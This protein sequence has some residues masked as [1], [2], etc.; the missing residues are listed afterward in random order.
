MKKTKNP[1]YKKGKPELAPSYC[2][3]VDILGF[4]KENKNKKK[5][6][7]KNAALQKFCDV[8]MKATEGLRYETKLDKMIP[9]KISPWKI[10]IF[11]DNILIG[12]PLNSKYF[13]DSESSFGQIIMEITYFQLE[14]ALN[15][16]FSRGGWSINWLYMDENIIY[17]DGLIEAYEL[18]KKAIYPCVILSDELLAIVQGVHMK[19]YG[20]KQ[21]APQYD[22]LLKDCKGRVF[23]NYLYGLVEDYPLFDE[24]LI[25]KTILLKRLKKHNKD[26][27]IL[28]K[29]EWLAD[30]HNYFCDTQIDGCPKKYY[31][32]RT[33][34]YGFSRI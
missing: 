8:F 34:K 14:L 28:S 26:I 6:E 33:V 7:Q 11:S 4:A 22:M 15:G 30:Y 29:Y 5:I 21:G 18:E 31:I 27:K 9:G 16:F 2:L 25:H 19:Y 23:V 3:F 20:R 10:K 1:Y 12:C 13:T 24:L 32:E 17:G